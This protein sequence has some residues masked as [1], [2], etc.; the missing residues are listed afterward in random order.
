MWK[1]I[2]VSDNQGVI[3]WSKVKTSGCQFAILRSVRASGK[4]DYQFD[5]NLAG[6]RNNN[7]PVGIYKYTYAKTEAAAEVEA[8]QVIELLKRNNLKC[9]VFWDVEDNTLKALSYVTLTNIIKA[10][11]KVIEAAGYEFCIYTG[12]YVYKEK[13]FD[14]SQFT[15]PLW[16]ARYPS[17]TQKSLQDTP[18]E[19]KKPDV[20]RPIL[21][22]QFSSKGSVPGISGNVDLDILY[23]NPEIL[24][25][26]A[27][28]KSDSCIFTTK[29][30]PLVYAKRLMSIANDLGISAC[31]YKEI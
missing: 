30:I 16:I 27:T 20:G 22:W 21:G 23:D 11:Q 18:D 8:S 24:I 2:D 19:T 25:T 1:G 5:N 7:I 6:C 26:N 28:E 15:C 29:E 12:L 3:D 13:W 14:F 9:K 17:G 31:I 4:T 10:A